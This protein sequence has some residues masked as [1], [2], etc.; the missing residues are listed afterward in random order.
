MM[1]RADIDHIV[2]EGWPGGVIGLVASRLADEYGRPAVVVDVRP[3][4]CR[5]SGRSVDGYD[6]VT[7][8]TSS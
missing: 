2:G 6:L 1:S 4:G 7:A 5:G 8:L 3:D